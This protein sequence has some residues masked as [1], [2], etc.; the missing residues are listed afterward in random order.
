MIRQ[1]SL[2]DFIKAEAQNLGFV[3]IGFTHPHPPESF[4][5]YQRWLE[6]KRHAE[7]AYLARADAIEQRADPRRL[8]PPVKTIA[9]LAFPYPRPEDTPPAE[10]Q[11]AG[12]VAAYAWG[13]DYHHLLPDVLRRLI[14]RVENFIAQPIRYKIFTDSAPILERDLARR[15]GLGWIGKNS[16]LIH[17]QHG[18]YFLLA[19]VFLDLEIEADTPFESDHCGTCR[20]CI[21]ACPTG[22]ILPNRT[23][24]A[25]RCISYLTIEN[26]AAIPLEL[27]SLGGDWVFGCDICQ[28]VCPWNLRFASALPVSALGGQKEHANPILTT[29]LRLTP[30]QFRE[31]FSH[32]P[33]T[34]AKRRGYLRNIAVALGNSNSPPV[35]A[36]LC[37]CL[38]HEEDPLVRAHAA[39]ALGKL[40]GASARAALEQ[41]S[42]TETQP[43]VQQEIHRALQ[44]I[45]AD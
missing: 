17:P 8:F 27:R 18:S 39:W 13:A 42:Q 25:G 14:S 38:K 40:G 4:P 11:P 36:P 2:K 26:K 30:Q 6:A 32:S 9:C 15:A 35:V 34:R 37:A 19:E 44:S 28:Q 12:R 21:D 29:E 22:C 24:D 3:H 33:I 23:L 16:C 10:D 20:R 45:P 43:A 31:K 1:S 7:M 41:A 5:V